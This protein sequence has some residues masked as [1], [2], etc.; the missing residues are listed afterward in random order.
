MTGLSR[1]GHGTWGLASQ[2]PGYFAAVA[3][4]AGA[5]HGVENSNNFGELP[6]FVSHNNQDNRVEY[7][8]AAE[9][10]RTIEQISWKDFQPVET[11]QITRHLTNDRIFLSTDSE[12]HDAWTELYLSRKFYE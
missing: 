5:A 7:N 2:S 10:V 4:I 1:G 11:L 12:S 9:A 3:P 8:E 6:I